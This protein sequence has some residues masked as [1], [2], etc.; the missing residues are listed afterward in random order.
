MTFKGTPAGAPPSRRGRI[1]IM[2]RRRARRAVARRRNAPSKRA[3]AP[4]RLRHCTTRRAAAPGQTCPTWG[5][6]RASGLRRSVQSQRP[7]W[8][9]RSAGRCH[10]PASPARRSAP[11]P[12]L[13]PLRR[14]GWWLRFQW[15]SQRYPSGWQPARVRAWT[16]RE[17]PEPDAVAVPSLRSAYP[18]WRRWLHLRYRRPETQLRPQAHRRFSPRYRAEER[19]RLA[20]CPAL[21]SHRPLLPAASRFADRNRM[22]AGPFSVEQLIPCRGG[23]YV[24]EPRASVAWPHEASLVRDVVDSAS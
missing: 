17:R 8:P 3:G 14:S 4:S 11:W 10:T 15:I 22:L 5:P 2:A 6:A 21:R 19:V 20:R 12:A 18:L 9:A 24:H 1:F 7:A 16:A 13:R 23:F